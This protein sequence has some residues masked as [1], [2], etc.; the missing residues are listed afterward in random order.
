MPT[1]GKILA[2][3][4]KTRKPGRQ[5]S[6]DFDFIRRK[7]L[8]PVFNLTKRNTVL[9]SWSF[10]YEIKGSSN[11]RSIIHI[12]LDSGLI[13]GAEG[14]HEELEKLDARLEGVG[15]QDTLAFQVKKISWRVEP[16][17]RAEC[18]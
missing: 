12:F 9:C 6:V 14:A 16:G 2:E 8:N 5:P 7:Y 18:G 17:C 10:K 4:N 3:L 1:W 15:C 11:P 13:M